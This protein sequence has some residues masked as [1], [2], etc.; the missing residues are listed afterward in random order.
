MRQEIVKLETLPSSP[1]PPLWEVGPS[2]LK[3][4]PAQGQQLSEVLVAESQGLEECGGG[5]ESAQAAIA[6]KAA[7]PEQAGGL[8]PERV[9]PPKRDRHNG[10]GTPAEDRHRPTVEARQA[11]PQQA[12]GTESA[13][14]DG[15]GSSTEEE[16][17]P[18]GDTIGE[19]DVETESGGRKAEAQPRKE[20]E[21]GPGPSSWDDPMALRWQAPVQ[22]N[23]HGK[24]VVAVAEEFGWRDGH[25]S[26]APLK[27][28]PNANL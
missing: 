18:I 14:N 7:V 26:T 1:A 4:S 2:P 13:I 15:E 19:R 11:S 21:Q 9:G 5:E 17:G 12:P 25:A 22:A 3:L 10:L 27:V 23:H 8:S 16:A 6:S 20:A 28:H 24:K